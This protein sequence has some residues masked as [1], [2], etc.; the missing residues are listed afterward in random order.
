MKAET[1]NQVKDILSQ[2]LEIEPDGRR[3]FLA[4][5]SATPE[6]IAEVESL[7]AYEDAAADPKGA[8]AIPLAHTFLY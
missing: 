1:W 2:A 6:I 4:K 5:A 7:L 3:E 8:P